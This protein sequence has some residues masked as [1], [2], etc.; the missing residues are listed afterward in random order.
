M[1]AIID[2]TGKKFGRWNVKGF[3]YNKNSVIFWNCVCDCGTERVV[4]G[5]GLKNGAQQ[6][7]GCLMRERNGS[8]KLTHG[9]ARHPAYRCWQMMKNRCQ[10]EAYNGFALYGGRGI[11][12]HPAWNEFEPFWAEMGTTWFKGAS[13][14]RIDTNGNYEPGNCRWATAKEQANNRRT[15]HQIMTPYGAMNITEAAE[16]F[17]ISPITIASRIRYG[18][19]E[20]ELLKPVRKRTKQ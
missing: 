12:I 9:M 14:D 20:K 19:P 15:N 7:C 2:L 8:L 11:Q 4:R 5:G 3:A 16:K 1:G 18:W 13:I 10:N 17:G 6:S